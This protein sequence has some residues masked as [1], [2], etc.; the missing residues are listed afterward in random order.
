M[1]SIK[2]GIAALL[3]AALIMPNLPAAAAEVSDVENVRE[4]GSETT[5][6]TNE[7]IAAAQPTT[8]EESV[9]TKATT[10]E[11]V[12]T[13]AETAEAESEKT[14]AAD[15]T[16]TAETQT[17]TEPT[18]AETVETEASEITTEAVTETE[19]TE[20]AV[21]TSADTITFNTGN[22][23]C[24]LS[25]SSFG[26]NG[27]YTIDIPEINP[28]F[29]YEVQFTYDGKT[30]NEWFMTP[31]DKV[32][33]DGHDFYVDAD[34]DNTAVTQLSLNVAGKTVVVYPEEK[35]F[36]DNGIADAYSLLP[37]EEKY[38]R[39]D[40]REFTPVEL[41][42]V[43]FDKIFTGDNQ[44][45][46]TSKVMCTYEHDGDEFVI[47][48]KD[49]GLNLSY[50]TVYGD[51]TDWQM[52]VGTADQ[53]A[54]TNIRYIVDT[55]ITASREW[56]VP[57]VYK[58]EKSGERTRIPTNS[59]NYSDYDW[60][61]RQ[62]NLWVSGRKL[63]QND[64]AY[65]SLQINPET[66]K[67]TGF[68]AL[69]VFE[70]KYETASGLSNAKEI[71]DAIWNADMTK[72]DAGYSI[73]PS[74]DIAITIVSY[75][76]SG[77]V[78][79][80]L[81]MEI[82]IGRDSNSISW[83]YLYDKDNN[84]VVYSSNVK[85]NSDGSSNYTLTL[86]KDY[87]ANGSYK[88]TMSENVYGVSGVKAYVGKYDTIA[89]AQAANAQDIGNTLFGSTGSTGYEAD[90]SKGIAF[91]AFVGA[92]DNE[93]QEK[94]YFTVKTVTGKVAKST[95]TSYDNSWLTDKSVP[96]GDPDT[97]VDFTGF[98]GVDSSNVYKIPYGLDS[99]G[100]FN[101][102]TFLVNENVDISKLKPEFTAKDG[103]NIYVDNA[104]QTSGTSEHNFSTG[105]IQY[106]AAST[107]GSRQENY[108]V[109]VKKIEGD[110]GKLYINSFADSSSGTTEQNG[111][112]HSK[113]ELIFDGYHKYQHDILIANI[114]KGSVSK[115]SAELHS[116]T[117]ILDEYWTLKG[118]YDLN[119]TAVLQKEKPYG[120][121]INLAR[122]RLK[123]KDSNSAGKK[124]TGTLTIKSDGKEVVVLNL[125]G[126]YGDPEITTTDIPQ[127][128]KFVPYGS[129]IRNN[130]KYKRNIVKYT[131][132]QGSIPSGMILR[133]NGELY[134]V[135]RYAG[136]YKFTVRMENSLPG[137]SD[138]YKQYTFTVK[139]NDDAS[140][141]NAT[142]T[143]YTVTTR[144]PN[145]P[146]SGI[147]DQLFVSEGVYTEFTAATQNV[148]LDG[149]RLEPGKDFTS[150]SGSTRITIKAETLDKA[151]KGKHTLGVEFR[152]DKT[153]NNSDSDDTKA[154]KSLMTAAQNF[155]IGKVGGGG[156]SGGGSSS[157]GGS[158]SS[159]SSASA[160]S[161]QPSGTKT[162][163]TVTPSGVTETAI[164]DTMYYSVFLPSDNAILRLSF[165]NKVYGN[166]ATIL[167]YLDNGIGYSL[168][169][170]AF[171][172][173][174]K[175]LN[176]STKETELEGF[177][178]GFKTIWLSVAEKTD[179]SYDLGINLTAGAE[180]ANH[181]AYIYIFDDTAGIF[182]PY[183][184]TIVAQ[185]GNI[186]F[187]T[188]RL[189]DFVVMIAE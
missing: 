7:T 180:Y 183:T 96:E 42:M 34:F 70:G 90:Y 137:L 182:T 28:F 49:N 73:A 147:V 40:L 88:L 120:E 160:P 67:E 100:E 161:A 164:D 127:A 114:G 107:D 6:E 117:L 32:T 17:V 99:Y 52:I 165:F 134:G 45:A 118:E 145:L 76:A 64:D 1:K 123:L 27:S 115:L 174:G 142:D 121:L 66:F 4:T 170:N 35:T 5:E 48:S 75:D 41:T 23:V 39:V 22:G 116:D 59:E 136:T 186:G 181:P 150:E 79:G 113:R 18:T 58:Q 102:V 112:V 13:E 179:L 21:K 139:N 171:L 54:G 132:Y 19:T 106:T 93:N 25:D 176:L 9:P 84:W 15:E 154:G 80:C 103:M 189:T 29:P 135:P 61:N 83:N 104:V 101:Y 133:E 119:S 157:D 105:A 185:G 82:Y 140:V 162:N 56:L 141:N 143:G 2:K 53:L 95:G 149:H 146:E 155:N 72:R 178:Q 55:Q 148:F 38:L 71:T 86:Y 172:S 50:C 151:G 166:N 97:A 77:K 8:T 60:D 173:A 30:K 81:P 108:W 74:R 85:S 68:S 57:T 138:R 168:N 111:V 175:D 131:R 11:A 169:M 63:G 62:N 187:Y 87:P 94:F 89:Q 188:R 152:T 129:I 14:E 78:T 43:Q 126:E 3:A 26:E 36:R 12:E 10:T 110:A 130:N 163:V 177:A 37:L 167:A 153:D 122:I 69:K 128:V 109:Q 46:D 158:S 91:T 44:I 184:E 92:D 125:T 20:E 65:L 124:I 24:A 31:D 47:S 33:V 98:S 156:S 51:E 16:Q 144:I 159:G